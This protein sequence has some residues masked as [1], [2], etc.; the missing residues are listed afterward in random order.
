MKLKTSDD[1]YQQ[2]LYT[3][4]IRRWGVM[5]RDGQHFTLTRTN[6]KK[7]EVHPDKHPLL[8]CVNLSR[9]PVR[10]IKTIKVSLFEIPDWLWD[11]FKILTSGGAVI[12]EIKCP[13]FSGAAYFP[14]I[15]EIIEQGKLLKLR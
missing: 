12:E 15:N 6:D 5:N 13:C 14:V 4:L 2:D 8:G 10:D 7:V 3:A 11:V 9:I 1:D